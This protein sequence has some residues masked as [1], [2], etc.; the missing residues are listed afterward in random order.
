MTTNEL[1]GLRIKERRIELGMSQ[2]ELAK[3][4][5]YSS[6]SM[7]SLIESGRRALDISQIAPL[8]E[9]LRCTVSD[10]VDGETDKRQEIIDILDG[11]S[12]DQMDAALKFLQ[13]MIA[14]K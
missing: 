10:I 12:P 11:L 3:K 6:R 14:S 1:I 5:G 13:V 4:L 9:A 8:T 7:I 2:V